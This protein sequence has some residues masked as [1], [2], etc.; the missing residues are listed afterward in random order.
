MKYNRVRKSSGR[1][2]SLIKQR[3]FHID[4][5]RLQPCGSV[6]AWGSFFRRNRLFLCYLWFW[7]KIL[8]FVTRDVGPKSPP[9]LGVDHGGGVP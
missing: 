6:H 5:F 4:G 7:H 1:M 3:L 2:N 8:A 9:L